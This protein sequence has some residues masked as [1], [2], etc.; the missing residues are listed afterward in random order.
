MIKRLQVKNYKSLKDVDIELGEKNVLVGPNMSGKS[1]FLDCLK[2]LTNICI[3]GVTQAFLS[4]GGFSEVA[5]KGFGGDR[6]SFQILIELERTPKES[7]KTFEYEISIMGA[8]SGLI[9]I[10][11]EHLIIAGN[12][13]SSTIIDLKNGQG[14]I[15]HI[16]GTTAFVNDN[17]SK[18]ALEYSVPGW[19]GMELKYYMSVWRYYRLSPEAMKQPYAA[20]SQSYLNERGENLSAWFMTMQ[21]GYP[22]EFALIKQAARDSLPGLEE[23]LT[24]PTQFGTTFMITKEKNI[25]K[26]IS[27]WHMS[28]GEILFLALLSLI[29]SPAQFGAPVFCVEEIENH[30]H[31]RLLEILVELTNQRRRELGS[32]LAQVF[33]TTHSPFFVDKAD[34]EELIVFGKSH[35][36]TKIMRPSSKKHLREILESEE[37]GLGELWYSGALGEDQ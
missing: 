4:R 33:V 37:L 27:L 6:I 16:D 5:W 18:S 10:E 3:Q 36:E 9:S 30:L 1:N 14:K 17:P 23:I 11:R 2:F 8:P 35:G 15:L 12:G 13:K 7:K 22:E 19:A 24:P 25:Q 28:D 21:T 32:N 26:P 31:P 34:L 29:F 20:V